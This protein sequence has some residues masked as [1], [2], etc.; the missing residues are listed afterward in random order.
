M[1]HD[2]KRKYRMFRSGKSGYYYYW[3][4]NDT[5]GS[6]YIDPNASV[7]AHKANKLVP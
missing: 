3:H 5:G 6:Y 4:D 7:W 1:S 2:V